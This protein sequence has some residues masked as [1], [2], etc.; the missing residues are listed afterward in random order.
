MLPLQRPPVRGI[1][2]VIVGIASWMASVM[3]GVAG[4]P[5]GPCDPKMVVF[6][7]GSGGPLPPYFF[8]TV[9]LAVG[10]IGIPLGVLQAFGPPGEWFGWGALVRAGI[11]ALPL[12]DRPRCPIADL[13]QL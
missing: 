3:T 7:M 4:G 8:M 2:L 9:L 5:S 1:G 6:L 12:P 13:L 11:Y 10:A